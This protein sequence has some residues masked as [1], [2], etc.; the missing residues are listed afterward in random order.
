MSPFVAAGVG[1]VPPPMTPRAPESAARNPPQLRPVAVPV[2]TTAGPIT[3]TLFP[4]TTDHHRMTHTRPSAPDR[5]PEP[6]ANIPSTPRVPPL[7]SSR[8]PRLAR[9]LLR[10]Y[11]RTATVTTARPHQTRTGTPPPAPFNSDTLASHPH[12][13][14][15]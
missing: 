15:R 4:Y 13:H 6:A 10:R 14:T 8:V 5:I 11:L 3:T 2:A 9:F 12:R 7:D 1:E